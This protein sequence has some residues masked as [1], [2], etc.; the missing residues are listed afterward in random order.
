MEKE[1]QFIFSSSIH[2]DTYELLTQE[3]SQE[4]DLLSKLA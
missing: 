3:V 2:T 4:I 1:L